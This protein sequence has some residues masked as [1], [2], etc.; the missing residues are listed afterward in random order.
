MKNIDV[1]V[2][3]PC[4]LIYSFFKVRGFKFYTVSH[5]CGHVN[6]ELLMT[7]PNSGQ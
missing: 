2:T 1:H 7:T 5:F 4:M 3:A 6:I